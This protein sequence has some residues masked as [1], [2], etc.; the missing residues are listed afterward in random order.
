MLTFDGQMI[1]RVDEISAKL[2]HLPFDQCRHAI[3]VVDIRPSPST[4]G[5]LVFV[6]GSLS[7]A[8]E[9][10]SRRFSQMFHLI[11]TVPGGFLV[12][13]EILRLNYA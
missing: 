4:G 7:L 6:R 5:I 11:P 1:Q 13:N 2:N 3:S 8:R 12:Q 10:P 9:E